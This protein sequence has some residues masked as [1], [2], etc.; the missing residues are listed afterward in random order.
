M[1]DLFEMQDEIVARIANTLNAQ[2]VGPRR[3]GPS[4]RLRPTPFD[5]W[6][7]G[8]AW[9]NKG[10]TFESMNKAHSFFN[11]L[12]PSIPPMSMRWLAWRRLMP[13]LQ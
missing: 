2:L 4:V 3:E 13:I 1:T 8:E 10:V 12:W 9:V 11:A 6:F 7:Q 5:L